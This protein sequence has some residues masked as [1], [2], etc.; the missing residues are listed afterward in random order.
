MGPHQ[1]YNTHHLDFVQA[2]ETG[3]QRI[4]GELDCLDREKKV[5][6]YQVA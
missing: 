4:Y 5:G 1:L 6:I 2:E 3:G